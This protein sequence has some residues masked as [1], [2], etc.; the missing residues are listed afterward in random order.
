MSHSYNVFC[1][2]DVAVVTLVVAIRPGAEV[3]STRVL[4]YIFEVLILI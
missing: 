4:E 1:D 3:L 2:R